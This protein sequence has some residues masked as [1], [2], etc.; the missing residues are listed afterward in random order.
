MQKVFAVTI[1]TFTLA[2]NT[3]ADLIDD[4]SKVSNDRLSVL[5]ETVQGSYDTPQVSN[6]TVSNSI[7][8]KKYSLQSWNISCKKD[9]FDNSKYCLLYKDDLHVSLSNGRYFIT[10]GTNH[11]PR[12]RSALKVDKNQTIY[13]HEGSIKNPVIV[14]EQLKKGSIAYTRFMKWPYEYNQDGEVDLTDFNE[15]FNEMKRQYNAL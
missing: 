6:S 5:V 2:T 12:S 7:L 11:F 15:N 3:L 4:N 9:V 8:A 13:G 1:L 14:I 10:I